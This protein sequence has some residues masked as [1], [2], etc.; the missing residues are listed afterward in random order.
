MTRP[1]PPL[2]P[3]HVFDAVAR[4]GSLTRAAE[5]LCVT[6]SA[7]SRQLATLEDYLGVTLFERG[8]R[9]VTLTRVGAT[10][11]NDVGPAFATIATA[12]SRLAGEAEGQPLRLCV[13]STFAAKWLMHRLHRFEQNHPSIP[14]ELSTT[15][16][17]IDFSNQS[18]D[19]AIQ[20][21]E[22]TWSGITSDFLFADVIEPVCSPGLLRI[23]PPLKSIDDLAHHRLLQSRYRKRDWH[24]WL[25]ALGRTD[26]DSIVGLH[27]GSFQNSLLAYQA[28]LEGLGIVMGQLHLLANDLASGQLIRPFRRP[29]VRTLGYYLMV[30]EGRARSRKVDAFRSWIL[31]ESRT[32]P[33]DEFAAL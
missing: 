32:I 20:L 1:I 29:V 8:P 4:H 10:Y 7:V 15:V 23:G 31:E 26:L 6:H 2:N 30:P 17:A 5:E 28:A 25:H 9:G 22:G 19:A 33:T 18:I 16:K 14:L 3:L 11:F 24:D 27:K 21:G 12:T 13:Y